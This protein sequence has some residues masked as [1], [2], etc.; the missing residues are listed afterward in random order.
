MA[1][2]AVAP[3]ALA[4]SDSVMVFAAASLK[5]AMDEVVGNYER[6]NP[7]RVRVSYA[8]SSTLARQIEQG[9]PAD[10]FVS[11]NQNWMD[12]LETRDMI[13]AS[14][15]FDLLRNTLVLVAPAN[16][17]N[18]IALDRPGELRSV[19]GDD[20][21]LAMANTDAVPAGIYGRQS[22]QRLGLWPGLQG[23][24]AQAEDVRA[25]LALVARGEAPLGVVYASDAVAEKK[26]RVVAKFA[27]DS[28]DPIVY[29]AALRAGV[30]NPAAEQ[31]LAYMRSDAA[32]AVFKRWGFA[33]VAH[34]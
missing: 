21:Y 6:H 1:L 12:R 7:T 2:G 34:D 32:R 8:G 20:G 11:A 26:V 33:V 19:L 30:D 27:A 25:A 14:S 4:D 31:L 5:N 16:S 22:L 24:I 15:R 10:V 17:D 18:R 29:P 9:A 28:H 3:A 13:R 23:R